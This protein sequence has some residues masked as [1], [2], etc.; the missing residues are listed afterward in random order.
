MRFTELWLVVDVLM[1]MFF[2]CEKWSSAIWSAVNSGFGPVLHARVSNLSANPCYTRRLLAE[3]MIRRAPH[4]LCYRN[5]YSRS[6]KFVNSGKNFTRF[7]DDSKPKLWFD[8]NLNQTKYVYTIHLI[9]PEL[10]RSVTSSRVNTN[11]KILAC[12]ANEISPIFLVNN[13]LTI[14]I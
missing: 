11:F 1:Q 4:G 10:R 5:A 12:V 9:G 7:T 8:T 6:S 14:I 2:V 13:S 3:R